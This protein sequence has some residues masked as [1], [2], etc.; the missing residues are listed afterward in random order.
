M[1][2]VKE[3]TKTGKPTDELTAQLEEIRAEQAE[4]RRLTALV[5]ASGLAAITAGLIVFAFVGGNGNS[6][7]SMGGGMHGNPGTANAP[8]GM[9]GQMSG[10]SMPMHGGTQSG[11]SP[12]PGNA[13]LVNSTL[14]EYWIRPS[15]TTVSAGKIT[16]TARN[17]GQVEHELMVERTPIEM[18]A[19][20][21]PNEEAAQG[22]IE[23]MAPGQSGKM[24]LNLRPGTYMLF[25]NV[26]GHFAA[27]QFTT[28]RVTG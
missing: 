16:F 24:T 14:G 5:I 22:M 19:P 15:S 6:T 9:A 8:Q 25:C 27:G 23:D 4:G 1:S 10:R 11:A 3:R 21:Q 20:G 12:A 17:V 13:H 26:A 2:T 7:I 28:L 18:D